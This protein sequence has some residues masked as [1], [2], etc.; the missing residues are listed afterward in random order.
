MSTL[1]SFILA[2]VFM[3][4]GTA[5]A[6]ATEVDVLVGQTR[7]RKPIKSLL[8][9]RRENVVVQNLDY[10]C[11]AAAL[12][13]V[14]RYGFEESIT[15]AEIIGFIFV[16]GTT[17]EEGYKKYFKRKGFTLLDLKRAARAKGYQSVGYKG[18][19]LLELLELLYTE[20]V[21]VLVPI[22][23]MDFN[24]FVVVKG[25]EGDRIL[26]A[27]PAVG[28]TTMSLNRFLD[29][30]ID[31]ISFV[32]KPRTLAGTDSQKSA[33]HE[34][35]VD[36]DRLSAAGVDSNAKAEYETPPS[37]ALLLPKDG[38]PLAAGWRKQPLWYT[39]STNDLARL[40]PTFQNQDGNNVITIFNVQGFT[41]GIQLGKPAGNFMDF[42][43]PGG[44]PIKSTPINN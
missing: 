26:L 2:V 42:S 34:S 22:K 23:P 1:I 6:W 29:V 28:N 21:P 19:N 15:E 20:R 18:M 13:T 16:F 27:D 17:P 7:Y 38:D 25:I 12:A 43:P 30:W 33:R 37:K 14:L 3:I 11:G 41:G 4:S 44:A 8:E 31:G 5:S 35:D 9:L 10:S 32:V 39:A 24:H 36:L 40:Q